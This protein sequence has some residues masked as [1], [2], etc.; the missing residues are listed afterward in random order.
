MQL[1][2]AV[3]M[4]ISGISF[5][6]GGI[7]IMN[8]MLLVVKERTREIGLRKAVGA[9]SY[10]VLLQFLSESLLISIVGAAAGVG[11]SYGLL[12]LLGHYYKAI[13]AHMPLYVVETSL[14]FSL[15]VGLIFGLWPAVK[16]VRVQPMDA[17]RYE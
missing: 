15:A 7:G 13:S 17:L 12:R 14:A 4:G 6:V 16:A 11:V 10:H 5:I 3:T 1:V 8:V 9:K 2:T